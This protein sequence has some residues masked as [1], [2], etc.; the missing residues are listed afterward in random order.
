MHRYDH[1]HASVVVV[2]PRAVLSKLRACSSR[3]G[4]S[5]TCELIDCRTNPFPSNTLAC[6]LDLCKLCTKQWLIRN[7]VLNTELRT[8]LSTNEA[9]SRRK[10]YGFNEISS[11]KTNLLKQ[12]LGYFTGP[13]LYGMQFAQLYWP[14]TN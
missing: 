1:H 13:I 8:G 7:A 10:R 14:C 2:R 9:D 11:E 12:F 4:A 6:I 3:C 5:V